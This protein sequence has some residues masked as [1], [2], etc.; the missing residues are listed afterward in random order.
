MSGQPTPPRILE[1][2]AKN[3]TDC[4]P[5]APVAGGRTNPFPEASQITITGGAASL[6]DGFPPLTMTDPAAGGIPPYGVDMNGILYL[7][8][9]WIAYLAAGQ[10]PEYDATLQTAMTGYAVGAKLSQAANPAALWTNIVAGNVTD[11]DTG[12]A[13]WVSSV[14]LNTTSAPTA[15]THNDVALS[16]PSDEIHDV[17]TAAGNIV[18]TGFVP[19]RNGQR[20][21]ITKTSSDTNTY[22]LSSLTGS[23]A[24]HQI[25]CPAGGILLVRQYDYVTIE[26]NSTVNAW[27]QV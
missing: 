4:T 26:F 2:F 13:G 16:T 24:G 14:A 3:A 11:P 23:A 8:S 27:V 20:L 18:T 9:S 1:A 22:T 5:A 21:T 15:G 12:G 10:L 25:R 17:S 6:N 7:L 19:G